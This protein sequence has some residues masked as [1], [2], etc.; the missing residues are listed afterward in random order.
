MSQHATFLLLG[1]ANGAV[2]RRARARTRRHAPQHEGAQLRGQRHRAPCRHPLLGAAARRV[3]PPGPGSPALDRHRQARL[4]ARRRVDLAVL[5]GAL[6]SPAVRRSSSGRCAP[7]R[8]RER[9][10]LRSGVSVVIVALISKREGT[11]PSP[12]DRIFP[13]GQFHLGDVR[14]RRIVSSSRRWSSSRRC[15]LGALALHAVRARQPRR[16]VEREGRVRQR[17]PRRSGCGIQLDV[18]RGGRRHRRHP[19]RADRPA[20]AH[21]VH[22]LHRARARRATLGRLPAARAGGARRPARSA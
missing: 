7:R 17:D 16:V 19:D 4:R 2:I 5:R 12:V 15:H 1:L 3:A 8:R 22:A 20:G 10:R 13:I 6:R 21:R 9:S 11:A 18:E 14:S